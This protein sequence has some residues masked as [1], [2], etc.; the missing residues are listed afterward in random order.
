MLFHCRP[1]L[2]Q[3]K[4]ASWMCK[5]HYCCL[6]SN[7]GV[8]VFLSPPFF[9]NSMLCIDLTVICSFSKETKVGSPAQLSTTGLSWI[10]LEISCLKGSCWNW[11]GEAEKIQSLQKSTRSPK[12][13]EQERHLK[14][15][16]LNA[17]SQQNQFILLSQEHCLIKV[18]LFNLT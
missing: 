5:L 12:I 13:Y 10:P 7:W 9:F 11:C 14:Q 16:C 2:F 18:E 1:I 4:Q 6:Q 8:G 17:D 15:H 3:T